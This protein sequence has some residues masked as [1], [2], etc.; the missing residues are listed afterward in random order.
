MS[1]K[2]AIDSKFLIRTGLIV[3]GGIAAYFLLKKL[4]GNDTGVGGDES[5]SPEAIDC[6]E[7]WDQYGYYTRDKNAYFVDADSIQ[8]AIVGSGLI[9]SPTEDDTLI[10]EI[11]KRANNGW[12]VAA[13]ICAFGERKPSLL[14]PAQPLPTWITAYLDN[15]IREQVN[16]DYANKG[17]TFRW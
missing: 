7:L 10:G 17:I 12:D 13:L 3:G 6:Q 4:F 8:A 16:Q 5:T 1:K 11:L 9:V 2:N 15:D 14:T